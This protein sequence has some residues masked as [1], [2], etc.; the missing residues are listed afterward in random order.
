MNKSILTSL[1]IFLLFFVE[2]VSAQESEN[3]LA[4]THYNF[5]HINDTLQPEQYHHEEM[6]LYM[7]QHSSY[8]TTYSMQRVTELLK[9]QMA[10]PGFDGNLTITGSGSGTPES[11]YTVP[12]KVLLQQVYRLGGDNYLLKDDYPTLDWKI[13]DKTK[14]IGGYTCQNAVVRFKG[15]DYNA[16]FAPEIP[17]PFG[18]WKLQGLPGLILEASDSRNQVVF[19]YL[20]FDKIEDSSTMIELPKEFIKT[21]KQDLTKLADA[22]KK[23]PMAAMGAKAQGGG[24]RRSASPMDGLDVN[25]IKSINVKKEGVVKSKV[26]NNP[27]E[28]E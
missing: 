16:W 12:S 7:G 1:L 13:G 19:T 8:Y 15:R 11:Y 10:D 17:F 18:P 14:E 23:N 3:A 20:G 2:K 5:V 9:K 6:V 27:I 22:Y 28:K 25:K 4:K 21:N 24:N 26:T